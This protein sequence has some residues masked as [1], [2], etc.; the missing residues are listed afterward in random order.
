MV[1]GAR[2]GR[3]DDGETILLWHRGLSITDIALGHALLA[4]AGAQGVGQR[5]RFA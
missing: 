2:P 4:K 5:L 3:E 1:A